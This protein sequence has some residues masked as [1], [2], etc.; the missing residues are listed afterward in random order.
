MNGRH[1][2]SHVAAGGV[3]LW[4]LG[5]GRCS[6]APYR[7]TTLGELGK[8]VFSYQC[9]DA[10]DSACPRDGDRPPHF[11]EMIAVGSSFLLDYDTLGDG[12]LDQSPVADLARLG[13]RVRVHRGRARLGGGRR[14]PG[15][16]G[17][18]HRPRADRHAGG[19]GPRRETRP[20]WRSAPPP[21]S[22]RPSAPTA[23]RSAPVRCP[24]AGGSSRRGSS[25]SRAICRTIGR[26]SPPS[27]P[28]WRR[29]RSATAR[30]RSR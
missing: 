21:P 10:T 28:G 18:R 20:S 2:V 16:R 5:C 13:R 30:T 1:G 17:V 14:V 24:T 3:L 9:A 8:G 23:A 12:G 19:A 15:G 11:P 25:R 6:D 27:A 4:I 22:S 29:C 7:G 26:G